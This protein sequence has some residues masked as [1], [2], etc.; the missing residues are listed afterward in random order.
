MANKDDN[1]EGITNRGKAAEEPG[2]DFVM[3]TVSEMEHQGV[4]DDLN[5][6]DRMEGGQEGW[7]RSRNLEPDSTEG[8]IRAQQDRPTES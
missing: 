5:T 6:D 2:Q 4:R 3:D 8:G 1:Q 7:Q